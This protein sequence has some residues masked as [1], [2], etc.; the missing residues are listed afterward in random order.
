MASVGASQ[1]ATGASHVLLLLAFGYV[2]GTQH[3]ESLS[4]SGSRAVIGGLLTAAVLVLVVAAVPQLRR[5]AGTRIRA[6]FAGVV[7]RMLDLLQRPTK[8]VTGFGGILLLNLFF[9]ACLDTSTRAFGHPLGFATVATV[10][11]V[12]TAAGS[13]IPTPGGIGAIEA[14]LAAALTLAGLPSAVAFSAVVL[15][16]LLTFWLP[17]L[18]GWAAF[19]Y[20]T[21]RKLL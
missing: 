7:P 18:P 8:L 6:L 17:M 20:L 4:P 9:I 10:Y 19:T 16:R 15:Y 13:A 12:G 1:L 21:R 3:T 11:L 2:T 14:A 5:F